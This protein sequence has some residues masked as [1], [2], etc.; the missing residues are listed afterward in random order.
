M[1]QYNDLLKT[2]IG[3][4][5]ERDDRTGTG[6][7][8]LFAEK[9]S[10]DLSEGFPLLGSRFIPF[11]SI[12]AELKWYLEGGTNSEDLRL[13]GSNVWDKWGLKYHTYP[14]T[15]ELTFTQRMQLFCNK[16]NCSVTM[17]STPEQIKHWSKIMDD[18]GIPSVT[19]EIEQKPLLRKGELGPVYGQQWRSFKGVR[20][21]PLTGDEQVVTVDQ[22]TD[23]IDGLINNPYSRRHIVTAW[24]PAVLPDEKEK[25]SVNILNGKA[26]LP[27]CHTFFQCYVSELNHSDRCRVFNKTN[28]GIAMSLNPEF[29]EK[30][31]MI[32]DKMGTPKQRLDMQ[33]YMRSC[34]APV[35]LPFNIATYALL[36]ELLAQRTSMV[37]GKLTIVFG[38]VH[39]YLN[40]LN[41]VK[42]LLG[43]EIPSLPQLILPKDTDLFNLDVHAV[44]EGLKDYKHNG[45]M[46][47][48]VAV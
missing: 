7:I 4:G 47:F 42:D 17:D 21:N 33:L 34:D 37:A 43:M 31:Q 41:H 6:T 29:T 8:S 32:M 2:I 20:K 27:A 18:N 40:Q 25:H 19:E 3:F 13:L 26:V 35:G 1:K 36:L 5:N 24:N 16:I 14:L 45:V 23:L 15:K 44:F 46:K 12:V 10:F 39:I 11:K 28:N 30:H 38:D 48:P 9:I 22:I